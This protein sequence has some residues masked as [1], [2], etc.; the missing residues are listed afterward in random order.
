MKWFGPSWGAAI[1]QEE[2]HIDV[3]IG[4][5]CG[6][7]EE[8]VAAGDRGVCVANGEGFEAPMH[9]E[10]FMRG[11]VGSVGHQK[12][13]CSCYGGDEED[14]PGVTVRQAAKAALLFFMKHKGFRQDDSDGNIVRRPGVFWPAG[15]LRLIRERIERHA[16]N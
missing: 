5:W 2:E 4:C 12:G 16:N 1:C 7:C 9:L 10:C 11:V 14:P 3:P 13:L 6:H 8:E 15:V